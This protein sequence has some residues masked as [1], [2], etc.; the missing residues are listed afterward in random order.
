MLPNFKC[1]RMPQMI[2]FIYCYY[3]WFSVFSKWYFTSFSCTFYFPLLH[4]FVFLTRVN[5]GACAAASWSV[6]HRNEAR[7]NMVTAFVGQTFEVGTC[8]F[9]ALFITHVMV[10]WNSYLEIQ[11]QKRKNKRSF[12][13]AGDQVESEKWKYAQILQEA[14]PGIHSI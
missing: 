3:Y 11:L 1:N 5:G 9:S 8:I 6:L 10:L 7:I 13:L 14:P 12:F 2:R 4:P